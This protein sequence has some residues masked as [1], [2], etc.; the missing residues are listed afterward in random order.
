MKRKRI[1]NSK[2]VIKEPKDASCYCPFTE[3]RFEDFTFRSLGQE[4]TQNIELKVCLDCGERLI[5]GRTVERMDSEINAKVLSLANERFEVPKGHIYLKYYKDVDVLVI[6]YRSNRPDDSKDD[7]V[8]SKENTDKGLIYNFD[9]EDRLKNIEVLGFYGKFT[10][11]KAIGKAKCI[12]TGGAVCLT[13]G[14]IY[15]LLEDKTAAKIH[16]VRVVDDR[17]DDYLYPSAWFDIQ[18]K[19]SERLKNEM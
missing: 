2:R 16:H 19:E 13:L 5:P 17:D 14:K 4:L 12:K 8:I 9:S 3:T 15:T 18:I 1:T 10:E 11:R 7:S 6:G